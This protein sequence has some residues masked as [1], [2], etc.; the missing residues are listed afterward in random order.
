M[1]L[2]EQSRGPRQQRRHGTR[3]TTQAD[4]ARRVRGEFGELGIHRFGLTEQP[5]R[6]LDQQLAGRREREGAARAFEQRCSDL[7]LEHGEL[8][9]HRR[10]AHHEFV[11]GGTHGSDAGEHVEQLESLQIQHAASCA[12]LMHSIDGFPR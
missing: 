1:R 6:P 3:E 9:R 12:D 10:G 2:G 11:R 7:G 4:A 8:L 5:A